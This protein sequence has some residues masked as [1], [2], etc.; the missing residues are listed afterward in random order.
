MYHVPSS[1][2]NTTQTGLVEHTYNPSTGEEEEKV[3][4]IFLLSE[5]EVSLS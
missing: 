1:I 2:P 3:K 4:V 5:F